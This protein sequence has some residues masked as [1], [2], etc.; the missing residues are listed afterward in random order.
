MAFKM[1][2]WSAFT[3]DDK[4]T[5]ANP[6]K[7]TKVTNKGEE[8]S[9]QDVARR[10]KKQ[11]TKAEGNLRKT[12]KEKDSNK[13][14]HLTQEQYNKIRERRIRKRR[15]SSDNSNTGDVAKPMQQPE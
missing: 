9:A 2:E 4:Q 8:E 10:I 7:N 12:E 3:K 13:P 15:R 14:S 11:S 6:N 5:A 1:N